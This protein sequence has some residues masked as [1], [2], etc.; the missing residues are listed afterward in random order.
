MSYHVEHFYAAVSVLTGDGHIKQ[1]LIK[2]YEENLVEINEDE[3][4]IA[5]KQPF[6]DL[7]HQMNRVTPL[8]GEGAI[9]ASVRKMSV[10][11]AA[12]CAVSVLAL[13]SEITRLGDSGQAMLPLAG[14]DHNGVPPF[15][16]KSN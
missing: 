15:L 14:K 6:S 9:C 3:L 12:D 16:V 4:P 8:N 10:N 1:R 2:A 13:F 11:E 7:K 5:V